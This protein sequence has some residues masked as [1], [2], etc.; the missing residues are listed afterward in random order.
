MQCIERAYRAPLPVL[1][2]IKND[3]KLLKI[4]DF[5]GRQFDRKNDDFHG[6]H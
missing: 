5:I 3:V 1:E 6:F 4:H 2:K